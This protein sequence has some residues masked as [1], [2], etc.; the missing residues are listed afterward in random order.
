MSCFAF[1]RHLLW[2][3]TAW[4]LQTVLHYSRLVF[5][6]SLKTFVMIIC[7]W[8]IWRNKTE[9]V[10]I[11]REV[12]K[13]RIKSLLEDQNLFALYNIR[14]SLSFSLPLSLS[15]RHPLLRAV[16][17]NLRQTLSCCFFKH[18]MCVKTAWEKSPSKFTAREL[19]EEAALHTPLFLS[20]WSLGDEC[21]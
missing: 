14:V 15:S 21:F 11:K 9:L 19:S 16:L 1:W 3:I 6:L 5:S 7:H 8:F 18:S 17:L 20:V 10:K 12:K 13:D 2:I 4:G